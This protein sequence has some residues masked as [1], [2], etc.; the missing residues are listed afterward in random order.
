MGNKRYLIG[1]ALVAAAAYIAY[2]ACYTIPPKA[3]AVQPFDL[4]KYLGKWYEIARI[5]FLFERNLSHT[6]AHYSLN[7][8]GTVKV[9]NRG[10]N[11]KS[12][13]NVESVGKAK[14]VG[15]PTEAKLKVSF[16]GPFYS[17]YNVIAIDDNYNNALV[18]GKNL[19]Y[20]WIL[21]RRKSI[22]EKKKSEFLAIA[23]EIGYDT[24]R[25]VWVNHEIAS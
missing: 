14:F 9:V 25:L 8:D 11:Y 20:L 2:D 1:G 15:D 24:S 13:K 4:E 22:S 10:F 19:D 16:F 21:S 3:T 17:G 23:E 6:S 18:C 5:D 7:D 12:G